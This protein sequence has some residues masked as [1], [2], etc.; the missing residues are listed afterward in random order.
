MEDYILDEEP[1]VQLPKVIHLFDEYGEV[2]T[3]NVNQSELIMEMQ[4]DELCNKNYHQKEWIE[5]NMK[6]SDYYR[7]VGFQKY[8]NFCEKESYKRQAK[9]EKDKSR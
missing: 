4:I 9:K 7:I 6:P 5:N 8:K 3:L 1:P 2:Q